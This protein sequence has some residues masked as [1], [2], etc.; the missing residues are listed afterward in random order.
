[1]V[2]SHGCFEF[3]WN[4]RQMHAFNSCMQNNSNVYAVALALA[5]SMQ[6]SWLYMI[7][8][9]DFHHCKNYQNQIHVQGRSF[10]LMHSLR[11]SGCAPRGYSKAVH[12]IR[13]HTN[14]EKLLKS[15]ARPGNQHLH[16][17]HVLMMSSKPFLLDFPPKGSTNV[18]TSWGQR[19]NA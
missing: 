6:S 1:M 15:E 11:T 10:V 14:G 17:S 9:L 2:A 3:M 5:A 12:H 4:E 19:L 18:T 8:P 7:F 13:K 16:L